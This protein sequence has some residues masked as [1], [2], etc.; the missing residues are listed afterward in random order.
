MVPKN[1]PAEFDLLL[2]NVGYKLHMARHAKREKITSVA[3]NIGV[4]HPVISQIENGRYYG[5]TLKLLCKLSDYYG[6]SLNDL[7]S[8]KM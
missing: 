1:Y 4:S 8:Y 2:E 6:M 5:L 3:C 7:L